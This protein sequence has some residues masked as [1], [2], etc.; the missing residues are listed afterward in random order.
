MKK[1]FRLAAIAMVLALLLAGCGNTNTS[2]NSNTFNRS[3]GLD[4]NGYWKDIKASDYVELCDTSKIEIQQSEIDDSINSLLVN[5]PS[6]LTVKDRAVI[7]GDTVNIDFV[8]K[9]DGVEFEGGST[10][11][12]GTEVT[13]G[14]TN[15]IDDFLEQLIGHIPGETFDVNVTFPDPYQSNTEL[16]GKDA[17]FTTTINH[18]VEK[19]KGTWTDEFVASMLSSQYGWKTTAEAEEDIKGSLAEEY[20]HANSKFIKDVPEFIINYQTDSALEYYR[21]IASM[22]NL[23][24]EDFIKAYFTVESLDEFKGTLKDQSKESAEFYLIYQALAEKLGYT[25]SEEDIKAYFK[26]Y[27]SNAENPEDYSSFVELYGMPYIKAMV[28]YENMSNKINELTTV[29]K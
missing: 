23:G 7:D 19:I 10:G 27:N 29:V 1:H 13:I 20:V 12:N 18:I 21:G 22:Y 17:V 5:F 2:N 11:G 16:S 6:T 28:L 24:L 26:K 25:P 15:Y 4:D 8:G 3:A 14:V 9:I